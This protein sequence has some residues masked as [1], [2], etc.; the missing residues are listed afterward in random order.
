MAEGFGNQAPGGETPRVESLGEAQVRWASWF[1]SLFA[2]FG[3]KFYP[4]EEEAMA[5]VCGAFIRRW[6]ALGKWKAPKK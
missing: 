6:P 3:V 2:I 1:K 4:F 5:K